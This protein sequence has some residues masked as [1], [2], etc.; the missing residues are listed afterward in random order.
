MT[1]SY[2][3]EQNDSTWNSV[4]LVY[5][6]HL[7]GAFTGLPIFLGAILSHIKSG[8]G[9]PAANSHLTSQ[10]RTFWVFVGMW[11]LGAITVWLLV[12]FLIWAVAWLW[13]VWQM[14]TGLSRASDYLPAE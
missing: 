9:G 4:K 5:I 3:E 2:V 8:Q 12:G 1:D 11:V 10:I 6:L 7:L 13:F 14:V